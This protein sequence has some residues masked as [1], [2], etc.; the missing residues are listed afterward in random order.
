MKTYL[1]PSDIVSYSLGVYAFYIMTLLIIATI[2]LNIPY[3]LWKITH[4]LMGIPLLLASAH[5]LLISSDISAYKPLR[6]WIL[7][8]LVA[9]IISYIYKVFLYNKFARRYKYI[10]DGVYTK[11]SIT[12]LY[13]KAVGKRLSFRAGEF[14]FAKFA[15][16]SV[17]H[18]P[19]PFTISSSPKQSHIRLS[20]KALGDYTAGIEGVK[21]GDRVDLKGPYGDLGNKFD[22]TEKTQIWIAGGIGITP[23]LAKINDGTT[24]NVYLYY[25]TRDKD[26]AIYDE[27]IQRKVL[28]QNHIKYINHCSAEKG[29]INLDLVE[30]E[31]GDLNN[32]KFFICGPMKMIESFKTDLKKK[33]I[34]N[35]NIMIED[36]NFK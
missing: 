12:E 17:S 20:V 35:R 7:I 31:V 24:R 14:I 29:H 26:E 18:E 27:E 9:A 32:K 28:G 16:D 5:V 11:G 19:H 22:E 1:F 25:C 15:S 33:G 36:F 2:G 10:V 13:L 8:L 4:T 21:R 34:K 23:F 6:A 3:N 30:K